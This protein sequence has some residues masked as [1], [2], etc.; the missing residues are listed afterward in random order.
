MKNIYPGAIDGGY[1]RNIKEYNPKNGCVDLMSMKVFYI[2]SEKSYLTNYTFL[3][4][5]IFVTYFTACLVKKF[6]QVTFF[7]MLS[8]SF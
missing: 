5:K 7:D 3:A 8:V 1:W 4:V 2:I 6:Y